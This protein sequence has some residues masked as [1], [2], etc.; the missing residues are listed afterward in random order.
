MRLV[1]VV[2]G[3]MKSCLLE[4]TTQR[5][6]LSKAG[7]LAIGSCLQSVDE[8]R[9]ISV[10]LEING[11]VDMLSPKETRLTRTLV[12]QIRNSFLMVAPFTVVTWTGILRSKVSAP[13]SARCA[14]KWALF[15]SLV[16]L[17]R[18]ERA[19]FTLPP[20]PPRPHPRPLFGLIRFWWVTVYA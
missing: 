11:D 5:Y 14:T 4:I 2:V 16:H 17:W 8:R 7:V 13:M 18:P 20:L 15:Y 10:D 1:G 12:L 6:L 9:G 3:D 19:K